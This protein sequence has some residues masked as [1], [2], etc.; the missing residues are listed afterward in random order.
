MSSL[1]LRSQLQL[2]R[3]C[4]REE[5]DLARMLEKLGLTYD[6]LRYRHNGAV[7][8]SAAEFRTIDDIEQADFGIPAVSFFSGCGGLDLGFETAGFRTIAAFEV[9]ENSCRTLRTNWPDLRVFGPPIHSGD[10]RKRN[11]IAGILEQKVGVTAP[12]EGI[13]H[14]GPPCQPF[15]IAAN[16]RFAKWGERFKRVGFTHEDYGTLLFDFIWYVRV[17]RPKAFLI[18]NVVGLQTIDGGMQLA[19]AL[20]ILRDEAGYNVVDP[21]VVEASWYGVPQKRQR[22]FII[23]WRGSGRFVAPKQQLLQVPCE[24]ALSLPLNAASNHVT[25]KHRASTV[26]RYMDLQYGERDQLGRADRLDPRKPSKTVIAGG[27]GGGGRSHLH[28]HHPR[29]LSPRECARLQTFP[30]RFRFEGPTAR[31]FTQIGNAVPPLL[32]WEW[33]RAIRRTVF[34]A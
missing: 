6:D 8:K 25:R 29:T 14:A 28:P 30:D 15:S 9:D 22:L 1:S 20:R 19:E 34:R 16:Q 4:V 11:E 5:A 32:A 17:F 26:L 12:F 21:L 3:K 2:L 31:Q 24:K 7:T 27:K 13:F 10:L 33:A 18:E 23:G